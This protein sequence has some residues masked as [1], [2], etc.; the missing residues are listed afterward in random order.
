MFTNNYSPISKVHYEDNNFHTDPRELLEDH[1]SDSRQVR[2]N[3][4]A[5]RSPRSA[6]LK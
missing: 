6:S 3:A 4:L 5:A 1:L 2:F